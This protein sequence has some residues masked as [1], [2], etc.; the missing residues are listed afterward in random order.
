ME[1]CDKTAHCPQAEAAADAAVSKVFAIIG[2]NVDDPEK[3]EAFREELRFGRRVKRYS[4]RSI[5]AVI[6]CIAVTC[7]IV[8]LAKF[9]IV[10]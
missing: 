5:M 4:D 7:T 8:L 6:S 3:V 1:Q 10:K 9:G 2:V